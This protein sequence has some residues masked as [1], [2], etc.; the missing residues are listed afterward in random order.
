MKKRRIR[1]LKGGSVWDVEGILFVELMEKARSYCNECRTRTKRGEKSV[2][3]TKIGHG[4]RYTMYV[5]FV[6]AF[7]R[8]AGP[9][10]PLGE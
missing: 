2:V 5:G 6:S 4:F 9:R 8:T 1:K 3:D 10:G 7:W